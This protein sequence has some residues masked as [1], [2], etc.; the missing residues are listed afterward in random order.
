MSDLQERLDFANQAALDVQP[1]ILEYFQNPDLE[2]IR[3]GDD[4][5]VTV[6]DKGAEERIRDAIAAKFPD[7]GI[8]GEEF[9]EVPGS[10]SYR[11]VLDPIDGTK[12]FVR[13]VPLFGTL[14]GLERDGKCVLGVSRFPGL[15]EVVYGAE[16]L[17][18]WWIRG[19]GSKRRAK[20]SEISSPDEALLCTAN[21]RRWTD[22]SMKEAF[23][24]FN[25][26]YRLTRGWADC[27]GHMLVATGRAEVMIDPVMSLWDAAAL[28]PIVKEAGGSFV[29]WAGEERADG[30]DGISVNAALK[31]DVLRRLG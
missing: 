11:W 25:T 13:G 7:D 29:T 16:G 9:D 19:D 2:V 28:L 15:N 12:P 24:L 20:V 6:A 26:D 31:E 1:F 27:Y 10:N 30:G 18:A 14:I 3:K 21:P 22:R 5:P 17:G 23:E 8:L 4:S